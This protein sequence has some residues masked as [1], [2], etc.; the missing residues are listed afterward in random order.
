MSNER[1]LVLNS[2]PP[3]PG[4][5]PF[6]KA[7]VDLGHEVVSAGPSGWSSMEESEFRRVAPECRH[8]LT[9]PD[10]PLSRIFHDI[11]WTPDGV[12][13]LDAGAT[14]WPSDLEDCPVPTVY[15][16][17]HYVRGSASAE[18]RF[19]YYDRY[20]VPCHADVYPARGYDHQVTA[21]DLKWWPAWYLPHFESNNRDVDISFFGWLHPTF[22][23]V[24]RDRSRLMARIRRLANE[25]VL[26]CVA[27]RTPYHAVQAMYARSKI[28]VEHSTEGKHL[29]HRTMDAMWAGAMV[30]APRQDP[31]TQCPMS[32]HLHDRHHIVYFEDDD[33]ALEQIRYYRT[34]HEE[35]N[36]IAERGRQ[37]VLDY[38][39][40]MA[41]EL[42]N[43]LLDDCFRSIPHDFLERRKDRLERFG[44]NERRR[45]LDRAKQFYWHAHDA[46]RALALCE[47][48]PG[49]E[50]D[51]HVRRCRAVAAVYAGEIQAYQDDIKAVL[52]KVPDHPFV[53][54]N[55]ATLCFEKR[56]DLGHEVAISETRSA[57]LA[58][59]KANPERWDPEEATGLYAACDME[60]FRAELDEICVAT[61][62][63]LQ[64][65]QMA[66]RL[67]VFQLRRNLGV[68]LAEAAQ[69]EPAYQA[70]RVAEQ[71][72]PDDGATLA[73]IG[74]ALNALNRAPEAISYY[75]RAVSLEPF[76]TEAVIA[77]ATLL[78][79]DDRAAEALALL[80]DSLFVHLDADELRLELHL[81]RGQI[82]SALDRREEAA[83]A[84]GD[85]LRELRTGQ[86]A[87]GALVVNRPA[88][89]I[90]PARLAD[91][92]GAFTAALGQ[93]A[94][95][96]PGD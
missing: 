30:L 57:L 8:L 40:G 19:C 56:E 4:S 51:L 2:Y 26:V 25:G 11:G 10:T 95:S 90:L 58:L 83:A 13:Q 75:R 74:K 89:A 37:F 70:L 61:V 69:W 63:G 87:V 91:W 33:D 36:A 44:V 5:Y 55:H 22:T 71:L 92:E 28:V 86:F 77:L 50:S 94:S 38:L 12:F 78:A 67:C 27:E 79:R 31:K 52:T 96:P 66:R 60:R 68:L 35:R 23:R 39:K 85:G 14:I 18:R 29:T 82:Y 81:L 65:S 21:D 47:A 32:E 80:N 24:H 48:V 76:F 41:S 84:W 93:D 20:V 34:H 64:R 16:H 6:H 54:F 49:W 42:G 62:P 73:Q 7:L 17:L 43:F 3:P 9:E 45:Q 88:A 72:M 59:Q 1:F 53:L 46:K 15:T